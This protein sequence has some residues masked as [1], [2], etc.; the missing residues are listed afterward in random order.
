MDEDSDNIVT[1]TEHLANNGDTRTH[2]DNDENET[3][4]SSDDLCR[5]RLRS[6]RPSSAK[7]W[8]RTKKHSDQV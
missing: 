5:S 4:Q 1:F 7:I 3:F 2:D 8:N 6:K